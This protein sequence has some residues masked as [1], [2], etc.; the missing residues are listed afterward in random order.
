MLAVFDHPAP[1]MH[2]A[3]TAAPAVHQARCLCGAVRIEARGASLW[4]AHCHCT[5]CQRAHGAGY[6]TWVGFHAADC[7]LH[8]D[9][10]TLRWYAATPAAERGFCSRCGS[11]ML[12][13][14]SRWPGE[15][16]LARALLTTPADRTPQAHVF[17][18]TH[19]DWALPDPGDGLPRENFPASV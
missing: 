2:D 4:M 19:V 15:L 7:T 14:S 18:S 11:P 9:G 10:N 16:H 1:T 6:V 13:R 5:L 12:F 17:W 3:V 8:D